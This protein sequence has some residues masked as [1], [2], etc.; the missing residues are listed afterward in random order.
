MLGY[1]DYS[2]PFELDTDASLQGL[3]TLLS[4]R[5]KNGT[6]HVISFTR[7]SLQLSK[8][9]MQN[10]SSAKLELLAL[11]SAVMENLRDYLLGSKFTIYTDINQLAYIKESKLGVAQI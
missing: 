9:S 5:D 4:Q 8:Q 11:K 1:P 10:Y 7:R 2:H 6:S 3:G